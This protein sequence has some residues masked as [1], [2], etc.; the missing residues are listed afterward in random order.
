MQATTVYY[1]ATYPSP[2]PDAES[3]PASTTTATTTATATNSAPS[4]TS[5]HTAQ[6]MTS[7]PLGN[8]IKRKQPIA[9]R[10]V[11]N[12]MMLDLVLVV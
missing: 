9:K 5:I 12:V 3:Q 11:K 1:T 8:G 4:V 10:L 6:D 2:Y 7:S